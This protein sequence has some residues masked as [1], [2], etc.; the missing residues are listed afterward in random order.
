MTVFC[1]DFCDVMGQVALLQA[2]SS[3]PGDATAPLMGEPLVGEREVTEAMESASVESI[4]TR[5]L[6]FVQ[7]YKSASNHWRMDVQA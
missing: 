1:R 4:A 2:A 6:D 7:P 3:R 5:G